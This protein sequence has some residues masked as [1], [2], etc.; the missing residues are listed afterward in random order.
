MENVFSIFDQIS[1]EPEKKAS[2]LPFNSELD[3]LEMPEGQKTPDPDS[4]IAVTDKVAHV[5][6]E[7]ENIP[8]TSEHPGSFSAQMSHDPISDT[9][10]QVTD[11][12]SPHDLGE[13]LLSVE[14]DVNRHNEDIGELQRKVGQI[15]ERVNVMVHLDD[16]LRKLEIAL[17]S[18]TGKLV[19]VAE[20]Q[21]ELHKSF[22]TYQSNTSRAIAAVERRAAEKQLRMNPKIETDSL[23]PPAEIEMSRSAATGEYVETPDTAKPSKSSSKVANLDDW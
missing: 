3:D 12:E 19:G 4:L 21:T 17:E 13:D 6:G 16:R 14:T 2:A 7:M 11:Q 23:V 18:L 9:R 8:A 10:S 15:G 20:R 5:I 1:K 22:A